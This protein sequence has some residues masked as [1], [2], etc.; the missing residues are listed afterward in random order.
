MCDICGESPAVIHMQQIDNDVVEHLDVCRRCAEDHGYSS[1][2][3]GDGPIQDM[4]EKLVSMAKDL[5]GDTE[6]HGVRCASC[7]LLFS[8]FTKTGRLGCPDCYEAFMGQLRIVFR[9]THGSTKHVGRKPGENEELREERRELRR[10]RSELARALRREEYES[11]ASLRDR[12][13]ELQTAV[14]A[15]PESEDAS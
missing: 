12:I 14:R 9:K 3:V 5:T 10:L 13:Q 15:Q 6:T 8:E 4:A 11:A 7:G 1:T 2:S